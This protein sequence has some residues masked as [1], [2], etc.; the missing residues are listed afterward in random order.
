MGK[1]TESAN[2]E[3]FE[4]IPKLN[5]YNNEV[6]TSLAKTLLSLQTKNKTI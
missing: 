6:I 2:K 1:R 5:K 3:A 4:I